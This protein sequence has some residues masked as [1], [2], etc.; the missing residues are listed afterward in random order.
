MLTLAL[1]YLGLTTS[2]SWDHVHTTLELVPGTFLSSYIGHAIMLTIHE[3][4]YEASLFI[5]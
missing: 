5:S 1:K 2:F 4:V 3:I